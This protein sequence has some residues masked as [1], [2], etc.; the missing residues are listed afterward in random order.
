MYEVTSP[1][2]IANVTDLRRSTNELFER[3]AAG[4]S[5]VIQRNTNPVAVLVDPQDWKELQEAR[6]QLLE[7][8]Q[9]LTAMRR[10][11]RIREGESDMLSH[12]E[13]LERLGI[14]EDELTGDDPDGG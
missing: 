9:T 4:T 10:E 7:I 5:V 12:G 6:E 14:T 2:T 3:V 8:E 13:M 1:T 11:K